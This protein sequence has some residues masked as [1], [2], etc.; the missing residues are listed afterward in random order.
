[1]ARS[2]A[3]ED[4]LAH[5]NEQLHWIKYVRWDSI[6]AW[7][8]KALKDG[9]A[10]SPVDRYPYAFASN[11]RAF[12]Q[13]SGGVL[14]LVTS[15]KYGKYLQAPA[16]VAGL[17]VTAVVPSGSPEAKHVD[18]GV[19]DH[20]RFVALAEKDPDTYLPMN[21]A[22]YLLRD[23]HFRGTRSV[24]PKEAFDKPGR[25]SQ[26][27]PY[28]LLPAHFQIHR[29][30][31]PE[32]AERVAGYAEAVCAGRRVFLS[33]RRRDFARTR[34]VERLAAALEEND[35]SC[36]L[37]QRH[38]PQ[39]Q[40]QELEIGLLANI[41][42]DAI[43]QTVWFVALVR[44]GYLDSL[45]DPSGKSWVQQE[46]SQ[47]AEEPE[48]PRRQEMTRVAVAFG[49][50]SKAGLAA[51]VDTNDV[52]LEVSEDCSPVGV[53]ASLLALLLCANTRG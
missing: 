5:E 12:P 36:W 18:K 10:E 52:V 38:I 20:G 41:L 23:L 2:W 3:N 29:V 48:R 11:E 27:S 37:D 42:D 14:W 35:V 46:W 44:P 40:A 49:R 16:L 45:A 6:V 31:T 30:L 15:P 33:Y 43:H 7:R 26:E 19:R 4:A 13:I 24:L 8:E 39:E 53:A 50:A 34:W 25:Q 28:A 17:K 22:T 9:G 32:S 47:A 21:N 51:W 1:M